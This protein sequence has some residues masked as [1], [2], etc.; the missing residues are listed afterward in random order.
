MLADDAT[1]K[2][3]KINIKKI[4][5]H[6]WMQ[7]WFNLYS[8]TY[9]HMVNIESMFIIYRYP[10]KWIDK[11]ARLIYPHLVWKYFIVYITCLWLIFFI[12]VNLTLPHGYIQTNIPTQDW[13]IW[14]RFHCPLSKTSS[15]FCSVVGGH[16]IAHFFPPWMVAL[17]KKCNAH[18]PHTLNFFKHPL[19]L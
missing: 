15:I 13:Y 11:L 7:F 19:L 10:N 4:I 8:T 12:F 17:F 18:F 6:T 2:N 3:W 14:S 1:S 5:D 16:L 9:T